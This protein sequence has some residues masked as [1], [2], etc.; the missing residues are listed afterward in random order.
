MTIKNLDKFKGKMRW[1]TISEDGKVL[2]KIP[3]QGTFEGSIYSATGGYF[4]D[5]KSHQNEALF[6]IAGVDKLQ[7]MENVLG[8][9]DRRN[10]D[11]PWMKSAEDVVK[12]LAELDKLY[13]TVLDPKEPEEPEQ[14]SIET[15]DFAPKKKHYSFNFTV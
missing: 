11:W 14:S 15:L 8:Y 3:Q 12:I 6:K 10:G 9:R 13:I 7:F 5:L 2:I 4:L 1:T